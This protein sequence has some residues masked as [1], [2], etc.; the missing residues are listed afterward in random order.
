[1]ECPVCGNKMLF[2]YLTPAYYRRV[3]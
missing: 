3:A 1:M 2:D